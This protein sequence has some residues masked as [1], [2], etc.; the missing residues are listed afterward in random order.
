MA[1]RGPAGNWLL[2]KPLMESLKDTTNNQVTIWF[3]VFKS[4][5]GFNSI[6][7]SG[8]PEN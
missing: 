3:E 6:S 7:L 1:V 2:L 5:Q 8:M 4:K